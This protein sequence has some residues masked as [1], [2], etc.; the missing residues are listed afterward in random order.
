MHSP[1]RPASRKAPKTSSGYWPVASISRA[2]GLTLSRASRRTEAWSSASSAGS[3]KSIGPEASPAAGP[4]PRAGSGRL[5]P[6]AQQPA[7]LPLGEA[8]PHPVALPVG[9]G[10]LQ[11]GLADRAGGADGL[12]L[13]RLLLRG[14][15]ED[16]RV[17]AAA[18]SALAPGRSHGG[19]SLPSAWPQIGRGTRAPG[20][21]AG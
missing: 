9:Q 7:P 6:V 20:G 17:E 13:G 14:G 8:A 16:R 1:S 21:Q 12:G 2:R 5:A 15:I 19:R 3:S 4:R 10:V 11:A 18:G